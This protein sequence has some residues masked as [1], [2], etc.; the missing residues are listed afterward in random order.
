MDA[1]LTLS[2]NKA[3]IDKAKEYA[4]ANK[5]SLSRL[6]EHYLASLVERNE[7]K[8]EITPFVESLGGVMELPE[9]YNLKDDYADFLIK[10][11]K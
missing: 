11:Y 8:G 5:I 2:L 1:K 3:I 9:D 4:K 6:I 10:K 7:N